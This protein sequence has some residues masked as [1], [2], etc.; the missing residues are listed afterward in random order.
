MIPLPY[1]DFSVA[2]MNRAYLQFVVDLRVT[3]LYLNP[4]YYPV[5]FSVFLFL[6]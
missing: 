2:R 5:C 4:S 3:K 6:P 1:N